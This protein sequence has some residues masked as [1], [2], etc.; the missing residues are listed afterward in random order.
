M[1]SNFRKASTGTAT[2][3]ERHYV[4]MANH[5]ATKYITTSDSS[6]MKSAERSMNG[7]DDKNITSDCRGLFTEDVV[8]M[9]F[10]KSKDAE[11]GRG[12][13]EMLR[14]E[15]ESST[16]NE[17]FNYGNL[18]QL[19]NT[20]N[21]RK[22]LSNFD[23]SEFV[24][25]GHRWKS[26]EHFFQAQKFIKRTPSHYKSFTMDSKSELSQQLGG[27]VKKAGGKSVIALNEKELH[28]WESIKHDEMRRAL[29]A[30]YSQNDDVYQ[31]LLATGNA[32][33][34]HKPSRSK[35]TFVEY[36]LM[37]V[38]QRLQI[39]KGIITKQRLEGDDAKHSQDIGDADAVLS[40]KRACNDDMAE[41]L[42]DDA[43]RRKKE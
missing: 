40:R 29:Y 19:S 5:K 11:P 21:W 14:I 34:T 30:K 37:F 8:L 16:N 43:Q 39:E 41:E 27:S 33:L 35:H 12:T 20:S 1:L 36:D 22:R 32:K 6:I 2:S 3:E 25:D 18:E 9:Y 38:R 31:I 17:R 42:K 4:G 7:K 13:G 10:S 15:Q 28:Q 23:H 26:V 24:L